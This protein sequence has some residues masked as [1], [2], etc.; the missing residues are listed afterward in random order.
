MARRRRSQINSYGVS[1]DKDASRHT[2]DKWRL[3]PHV[4]RFY[5]TSS[6]ILEHG[7]GIGKPYHMPVAVHS[8]VH[9]TKTIFSHFMRNYLRSHFQI[10]ISSRCGNLKW[11]VC[12]LKHRHLHNEVHTQRTLFNLLSYKFLWL[13]YSPLLLLLHLPPSSSLLRGLFINSCLQLYNFLMHCV[14]LV[15]FFLS[16]FLCV[17]CIRCTPF[18][19]ENERSNSQHP[20]H[21]QTHSC[22]GAQTHGN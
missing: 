21:F 17:W 9:F 5:W 22:F 2:R 6:A 18:L 7:N 13:V 11:C 10:I 15:A 14:A 4:S 12:M 1:L 16:V 8:R 19:G 20:I 3:M